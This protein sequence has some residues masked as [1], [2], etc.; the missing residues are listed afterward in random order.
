[1]G[2]GLVIGSIGHTQLVTTITH[3]PEYSRQSRPSVPC[4]CK[5]QVHTHFS[6]LLRSVLSENS[7][8]D[9]IITGLRT[10][11]DR[12]PFDKHWRTGRV[13]YKTKN[14]WWFWH[15]VQKEM[16]SHV[17]LWVKFNELDNGQVIDRTG[18]CQAKYRGC[19]RSDPM[20]PN[21][22]FLILRFVTEEDRRQVHY[23]QK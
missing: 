13:N 12:V 3:R 18:W 19:L 2:F 16:V 6:Q 14:R 22:L 1:M 23:W 11:D 4:V 5:S 7:T 17:D 10:P 15:S 9:F 8:P 20:Q 21:V